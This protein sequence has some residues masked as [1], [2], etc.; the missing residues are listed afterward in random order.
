MYGGS[1][2]GKVV[3]EKGEIRESGIKFLIQGPGL[4]HR[5]ALGGA[6]RGVFFFRPRKLTHAAL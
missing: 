4:L 1:M 6:T 2:V 3:E 5:G